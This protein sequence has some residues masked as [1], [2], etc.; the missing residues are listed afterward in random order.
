M[1]PEGTRSRTE[2]MLPFK[3]GAFVLAI[4]AQ[5]PIVPMT[6]IGADRLLAP[7]TPWLYPGVIRVL[8]HDP[9]ETTGLSVDRRGELLDRAHNVIQDS[10]L[11]HK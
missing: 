8:I 10:W 6:M 5:V 2:D 11:Q 3:K 4:Q 1:F 7:D 9:I